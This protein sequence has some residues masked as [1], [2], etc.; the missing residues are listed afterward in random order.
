MNEVIQ[1][2]AIP[3]STREE[4]HTFQCIHYIV[5]HEKQWKDQG[6]QQ[7]EC[8][9][10]AAFNDNNYCA[11]RVIALEKSL[12]PAPIKTMMIYAWT[13][14]QN[15]CRNLEFRIDDFFQNRESPDTYLTFFPNE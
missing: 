3:Y 9:A 6:T 15:R 5:R 10:I 12:L 11:D 13:H 14:L 1:I 4:M 8:I 7:L 2:D